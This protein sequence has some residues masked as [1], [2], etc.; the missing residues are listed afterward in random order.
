ME[1]EDKFMQGIANGVWVTMITPFTNENKVDYDCIPAMVDW[2]AKAGCQGIFA[3]CQSSEMFYLSLEERVQLA[4]SVIS[5]A[6][7]K[8]DVIVSGHVSDS[9]DDQVQEVRAMSQVGAKAVVIVTNRFAGREESDD[10]WLD[11]MKRMLDAVPNCTFGMYECPY[12]YKRLMTPEMLR[13]CANTNRFA[14]LKDTS[15][16]MV[17]MQ[18]KLAALAGSELKLFNANSATLLD[19]LIAGCAGFSGVMANFHPEFYVWLCEH[20]QNS[21]E[22][23]SLLSAYLSIMS[24]IEGHCY[25]I[26]AKQHM[27]KMGIPM[28]VLTRSRNMLDWNALFELEVDQLI[29]IETAIKQWLI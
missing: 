28:T 3:V 9:W 1:R 19:T 23:A 12:P 15:C 22:K 13:I 4:K 5:A 10:V 17:Q 24:G 11:N 20:Y 14:F 21:P 7:G 29:Q 26:S 27:R 25:P 16:N 6:K 2:Y 8:I 18:D